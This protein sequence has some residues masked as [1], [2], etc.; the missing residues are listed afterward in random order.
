M[1][2]TFIIFMNILF[3]MVVAADVVSVKYGYDSKLP[4]VTK[5]SYHELQAQVEQP[6]QTA[7]MYILNS[8]KL[9]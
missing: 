2:N 3:I 4:K 9:Q 5:S 1:K 6:L 8:Y 7:D